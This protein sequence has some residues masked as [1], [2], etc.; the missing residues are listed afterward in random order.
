MKSLTSLRA[1]SEHF[2][3]TV[4]AETLCSQVLPFSIRARTPGGHARPRWNKTNSVAGR[5]SNKSVLKRERRVAAGEEIPQ[6]ERA[7]IAGNLLRDRCRES[8]AATDP[9]DK[10]PNPAC[11]VLWAATAPKFC[12]SAQG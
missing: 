2:P 9:A 3:R 10:A 8:H 4:R 1:F 6:L 11:G 7:G 12:L 5:S